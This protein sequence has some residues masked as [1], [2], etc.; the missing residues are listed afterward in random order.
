MLS[1]GRAVLIAAG[2]CA[3]LACN[4]RDTDVKRRDEWIAHETATHDVYLRRFLNGTPDVVYFDGWYPLEHDPKTGGAWRW[5]RQ[6]SITRLRAP[7]QAKDMTVTVWGWTAYE[8]VGDGH[9]LHMDFYVNG[10][11][12]EHFEPPAKLFHHTIFVPKYLLENSE[13]VD[14]VIRVAN[15]AVPRGDW[16]SLAF[17]TTGIIWQPAEGT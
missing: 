10:R 14:L 1:F 6:R 5:M 8:F 13:W 17:A 4:K 15:W 11:L 2:A 12:L 7:K 3:L 9:T 16:R